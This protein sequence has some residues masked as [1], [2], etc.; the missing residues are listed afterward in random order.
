MPNMPSQISQ[1]NPSQYGQYPSQFPAQLNPNQYMPAN[2]GANA[3]APTGSASAASEPEA[4]I[5]TKDGSTSQNG[6]PN[7]MPNMPNMPNMPSM[8]NMPDQFNYNQLSQ[9]QNQFGQYIPS[10][11]PGAPSTTISPHP[12]GGTGARR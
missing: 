3:V 5:S 8:P 7:Y 4:S 12:N 6:L 11:T 2:P 1:L 10:N 9:Y